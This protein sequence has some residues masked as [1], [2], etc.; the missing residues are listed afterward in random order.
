M[1]PRLYF[2]VKL[3]ILAVIALAVLLISIFIFNFILF[4]IRL[5]SHDV[6]LGFGPRGFLTFL[7]FFPWSWL[8]VDLILIGGLEW[9]LRRFRFGYKI[10]ILYLLA[11]ILFATVA[12]GFVFDRGTDWNDRMLRRA[13][14]HHPPLP[15][16]FHAEEMFEGVYRQARRPLPPRSGICKCIIVSIEKNVLTAQDTRTGTTTVLT[17]V[18]PLNDP[19]ATTTSLEVG[20]IVFIA[21]DRENDSIRAFGVRKMINPTPHPLPSTVPNP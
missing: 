21:G 19:H 20:D 18:L 12:L 1:R 16:N 4:S 13:E 3:V 2:T 8:I 11:G 6:F 17:I 7:Y 15:F 14:L 9:L 5:N 10:P